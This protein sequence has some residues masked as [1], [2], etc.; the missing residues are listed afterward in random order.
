MTEINDK[1]PILTRE[2]IIV[3][4]LGD[5]IQIVDILSK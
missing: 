4:F 2:F 3:K 1:R 5:F